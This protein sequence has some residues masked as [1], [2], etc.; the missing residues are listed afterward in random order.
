MQLIH[1]ILLLLFLLANVSSVSGI[2]HHEL[3]NSNESRHFAKQA[4]IWEDKTGEVSF[5]IIL[6]SNGISSLEN[7][8][9]ATSDIPFMDF[10]TSAFWMELGIQNSNNVAKVFN[11]EIAR[12]LTNQVEIYLV[13]ELNHIEQSFFS[14]D[15]LNFEER[16]FD[17]RKFIFPLKFDA[18]RKYRLFIRAKSDGEILKLPIKFWSKKGLLEFSTKE[19]FFLGSYYGFIALVVILFT[20]FGVALREKIYFFFV[21]YVFIMGM[22]Q[23]SLD[24]FA[25]EFLWPHSSYLGNHSILVFAAISMLSLLAYANQFLE[26]YKEKK[27]F[28]NLYWL[29]FGLVSFFLITSLTTGWF[30]EITYPLLNGISFLITT[31][32]FLGIYLKYKSGHKPGFEITLAFAFLWAGAISFILSNV[33]IIPSD[34]LAANSLKIASAVEI[35]FLSISLAARYRKTQDDKLSAEQKA[36]ENLEQLNQLKSEQTEVLE[37]EVSLRT[38]EVVSQNVKL[39]HQNSEIIQSI[40]YAQRLQN[41]IL[42]SNKLLEATFPQYNIYF[43]PKDI[44]SGDFYWIEIKGDYVYFAVA[45]CT[46]HGV[47]GALVSVVGHN[48]LNR[49]INELNLSD[50]GEIL[51]R[52]TNLVEHTFNKENSVVSDGMDI[53]FCRWN[54]KEELIYAGA[55]NPLYLLRNQEFIEFKADRQPIGKFIKKTPFTSQKINLKKGDQIFL[56]SDGYPDQFGGKKG[57]KLK[58]KAFKNIL[59]TSSL[60][61]VE[62]FEK[63]MDKHFGSWTVNEEQID[64]ICILKI[65][66]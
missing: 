9:Q 7:T 28:T 52:L 13:N 53:C 17:Y 31:F 62:Q 45:D 46:G 49:C 51:D 11:I 26:F 3:P 21:S 2:V 12:P 18:N 1:R 32:F 60:L 50:P 48:A 8:F 44:V 38:Q 15:D 58:S 23:L 64:D 19:N 39:E 14:G 54:Y 16:P 41:A 34:F 5:D 65:S 56:F 40:N 47:P 42:P 37:K 4:L 59:K 22:F 30:Y 20:F 24:G 35:A 66:F 29:F 27:W 57:K 6:T 61:P 55:F 43:R 36:V 25:Y 63:E 33:N 10:T